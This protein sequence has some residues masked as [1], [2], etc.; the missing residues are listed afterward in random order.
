MVI[1]LLFACLF[2]FLLLFLLLSLLLFLFLSLFFFSFLA[3]SRHFISPDDRMHFDS[4]HQPHHH[5]NNPHPNHII[6][7]KLPAKP[8]L[9]PKTTSILLPIKK[10]P[11][12]THP[13]H[14]FDSL[15]QIA[16]SAAEPVTEVHHLGC[17]YQLNSDHFMTQTRQK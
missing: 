12:P 16:R 4:Q 8:I 3:L 1:H 17:E 9:L 14:F 10:L 15:P 13:L 11:I 6:L 5:S 2:L 7:H